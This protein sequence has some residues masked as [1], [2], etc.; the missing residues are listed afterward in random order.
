VEIFP[1]EGTDFMILITVT[2]LRLTKPPLWD[3]PEYFF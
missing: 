3:S 1:E 2:A